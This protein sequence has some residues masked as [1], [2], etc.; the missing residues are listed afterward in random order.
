VAN[1]SLWTDLKILLRTV[2]YML[3]RRGM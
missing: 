3:A 1:W 2:P